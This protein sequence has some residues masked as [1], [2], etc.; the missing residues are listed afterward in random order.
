[1]FKRKKEKKGKKEIT[2]DT[3]LWQ[4]QLFTNEFENIDGMHKG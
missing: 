1:M 4:N 3:F 2:K